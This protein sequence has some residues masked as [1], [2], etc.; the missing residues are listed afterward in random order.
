MIPAEQPR[1]RSRSL[2][3]VASGAFL[4]AGAALLLGSASMQNGTAPGA[5]AA[6]AGSAQAAP[7]QAT[8]GLPPGRPKPTDLQIKTETMAAMQVLNQFVG[9]WDV[10]GQSFDETGKAVGDFQGSAHYSFTMAQN[11]LVGEMTL[12]NGNFV[13]DQ[14]DYFGYSPGL[15]KYTHIMLTELDK[16]MVYQQGEWMPEVGSM[17]FA[18]AAPLD[19]P[20]GTPR[21]IS[22]EYGFEP[23]KITLTM[24]MQSGTKAPRTVRML[25]TPSQQ[26]NAPTGPEG[27]PTG[28][29]NVR[30]QYQQGDPAQMRAQ[31]Q[32]AVGQ[33]TAQKA[34]MAQYINTMN[35]GW[36]GQMDQLM[37]QQMDQG[38]REMDAQEFRG[39]Q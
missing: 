36:D 16:S 8:N 33:M 21:N 38:N 37:N 12:I 14:T 15:R 22:I 3:L 28:Q 27:L 10:V 6:Q 13:L 34:A 31:M 26:P 39:P 19:T 2:A 32:Q 11:F 25:M 29:G 35:Q 17:V 20:R 24:T 30:V 5:A 18:M 4:G 7:A 1:P 9:R 23:Q